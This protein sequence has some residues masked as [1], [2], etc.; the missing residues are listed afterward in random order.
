ML[1]LLVFKVDQGIS[2]NLD[3]NRRS[4]SVERRPLFA[5]KEGLACEFFMEM[6]FVWLVSLELLMQ[7][8]LK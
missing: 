4:L 8:T 7:G 2:Q 1:G 5:L 3:L 6:A